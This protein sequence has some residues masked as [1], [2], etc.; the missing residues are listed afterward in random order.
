VSEEDTGAMIYPVGPASGQDDWWDLCY[1][2]EEKACGGGAGGRLK[3][4]RLLEG[5]KQKKILLKGL[6]REQQ[7]VS[8]ESLFVAG[9]IGLFQSMN[10]HYGGRSGEYGRRVKREGVIY[11]DPSQKTP[12]CDPPEGSEIKTKA[13]GHLSLSVS[14]KLISCRRYLRRS[15]VF[16][17]KGRACA[18]KKE[19]AKL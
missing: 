17:G 3:S 14:E 16:K 19:K 2:K 4:L 12:Q 1:G 5:D 18:D 13:G 9:D 15:Y 6:A 7:A 11:E 10:G 8:L